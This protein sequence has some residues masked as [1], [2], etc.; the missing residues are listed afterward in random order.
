MAGLGTAAMLSK[1]TTHAKKLGIFERVLTHEPKSAPGSGLSCIV[2]C[3]SIVPLAAASG[4][5]ST[6]A[7]VLWSIQLRMPFTSAPEDAIDTKL[8]D[9]VDKLFT[10]YTQDFDLGDSVKQIDILGQHGIPLQAT[11]GYLEQDKAVY[12]TMAIS[13]PVIV[14]DAWPQ[15]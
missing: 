5:A 3:A 10:E 2:W 9:A 8:M 12:R 7:R 1:L 6:T 15:G 11:G 13:M 4:L 14:N